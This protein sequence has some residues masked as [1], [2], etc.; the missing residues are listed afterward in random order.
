MQTKKCQVL[1]IGA[2]PGGY[3]AAIR[4]GQLGLKTIIVEGEKA[5]G[6]CLIRGCIPSKALIHAAHRFHFTFAKHA[7]KDGHMGISIPAC[8]IK[9]V[10]NG[11]L[12]R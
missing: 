7:E 3:V 9:Y 10:K 6:T 11:R 12:E 1:V 8:R 5:G 4:A 2:G